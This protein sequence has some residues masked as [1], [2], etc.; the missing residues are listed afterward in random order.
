M[1][2]QSDFEWAAGEFERTAERLDEL[3]ALP[4]RLLGLGVTIGG[5]LT[6]D[7]HALFDR[8]GG[9]L[10]SHAD[11]LHDLALTCRSRAAACADYRAQ[12]AAYDVA[13]D[14]HAGELRRWHAMALA[15]DE[16]PTTVAAPGPPPV[17]PIAP[18]DPPVWL[19]PGAA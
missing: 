16:N 19:S 18:A 12:R 9:S 8:V 2:T 15:H 14:L 4:R 10:R 3:V 17:A 7:L 1:P 5:Q 13:R 6:A 11:E